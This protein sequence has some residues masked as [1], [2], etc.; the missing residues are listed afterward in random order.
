MTRVIGYIV[1]FLLHT[2]FSCS[3]GW[4]QFGNS[5]YHVST[6]H[7]SWMDG[8]RMCQMHGGYLAHVES[9]SEDDFLKQLM[10]QNGIDEAW[11]G[12]SDW[13]MEGT[14]VWEPD[15]HMFLYS[16]FAQGRPNNY[17]GENCLSK[18]HGHSYKWDDDD[19]DSHRSYLCEKPAVG[20]VNGIIG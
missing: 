15:G 1:L 9:Q 20:N 8:M 17:Q 2:A 5:C 19:C 18:E 4:T 3:P 16:N 6:E 12:G 14:W 10:K 11:L 13:T 7:E